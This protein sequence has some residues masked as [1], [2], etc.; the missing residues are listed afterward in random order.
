MALIEQ[1]EEFQTTMNKVMELVEETK[2]LAAQIENFSIGEARE[3]MKVILDLCADGIKNLQDATSQ[4]EDI[5][6][7][8]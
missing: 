1:I 8:L 7:I 6:K 4:A 3:K 5:Q 2:D